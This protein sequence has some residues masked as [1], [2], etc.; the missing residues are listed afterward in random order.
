MNSGKKEYLRS[1]EIVDVKIVFTKPKDS[2]QGLEFPNVRIRDSSQSE[3]PLQSMINAGWEPKGYDYYM[4]LYRYSKVVSIRTIIKIEIEFN[5]KVQTSGKDRVIVERHQYPVPNL[6]RDEI[7]QSAYAGNP[8]SDNMKE[9][10]I[11]QLGD[12][13]YR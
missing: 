11:A 2:T 4:G 13:L 9:Q 1:F 7:A 3:V 10:I 6:L 12:E 5:K 8:L